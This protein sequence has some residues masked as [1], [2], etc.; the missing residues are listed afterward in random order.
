MTVILVNQEDASNLANEEKVKWALRVLETI[1]LPVEEWQIEPTM[2]NLRMIRR[3]LKERSIDV[4]DDTD[5]GLEIYY[6]NTLIGEW[7]KPTYVLR[8]DPKEKSIHYRYY[9]E[10]HINDK[11]YLDQYTEE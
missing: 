10:M 5:G 9:L 1:G 8:E 3:Q 6:N 7:R 2:D 4:I 11:L